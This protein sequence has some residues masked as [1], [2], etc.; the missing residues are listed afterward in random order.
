LKG[1]VQIATGEDAFIVAATGKELKEQPPQLLRLRQPEGC[2]WER[3]ESFASLSMTGSTS[4]RL[5]LGKN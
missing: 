5:Q 2:N 4:F 1:P 3:I